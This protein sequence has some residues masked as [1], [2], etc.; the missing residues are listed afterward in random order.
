V[1]RRFS[2]SLPGGEAWPS[3]C[4]WGRRPGGG[5]VAIARIVI[6]GAGVV[7]LGAA[8]LLCGDGHEVTVLER[9]AEAPPAG[10]E[11]IWGTWQRKGV[12]QFRLPHFFLA[13][14]RGL[15]DSELPEVKKGLVAAGAVRLNPVLD[16]PEEIRG[17]AREEDGAFDCISGRRCVVEAA[18][19]SVAGRAPGLEIRRGATV[20]GLVTGPSAHDGV[21]HVTGVR[22]STGEELAADLVVDM[23][24]R[25]SHLPRWLEAI[26]AQAARDELDDC[27]FIYYGRHFRSADGGIPPALGGFVMHLG[28]ISALTLPADNGTWSVT[29]VT[30]AKDKALRLLRDAAIWEKAVRSLPLVAHWLDGK[31]IDDRVSALAGIE[32]RHRNLMV[33]GAPVATGVV[34]AGDAWACSNPSVGRGASIG[35]LQAVALRDTIAATGLDDPW[36]FA[37]SFHHATAETVEPW[38]RETL[39]ADRH[40][41]AEIDALIAGSE[42]RPRDPGWEISQTLAAAAFK[43]ADCFRGFVSNAMLLNRVADV[44]ARPGL[45]D[46]VT[47][48]GAGWRDEPVPAP[49]RGELLSIV[50]GD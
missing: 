12:N 49:S 10:A 40:R 31:P 8:L 50:A 19:A 42:Y 13:R 25:R 20:A 21:P 24:G 14:Y 16:A 11:E 2:G 39:A 35:M 27:G 6:V 29:L 47:A 3:I 17:S 9:D 41:L 15:L 23:T 26:G 45:L 38:Y 48:L 5:R 18:V 44:A 22:L 46:K 32:D 1:A 30:S 28:T 43:D 33:G 4:F 34:A 37:C 7:G 36:E